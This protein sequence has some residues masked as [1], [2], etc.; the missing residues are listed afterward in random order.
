VSDNATKHALILAGIG[1][2]SLPLWLIE[3]DLAEGRLVRIA[4]AEFQGNRATRS[5]GQNWPAMLPQWGQ[6]SPFIIATPWQFRLPG[7]S[8]LPVG[9]G[10]SWANRSVVAPSPNTCRC[11]GTEA[12]PFNGRTEAVAL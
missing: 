12:L 1:W 2:G 4:A 9:M 10:S 3:R 8:A 5:C 7:T 11:I 6:I